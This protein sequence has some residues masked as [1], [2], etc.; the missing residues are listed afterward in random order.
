MRKPGWIPDISDDEITQMLEHITPLVR[1]GGGGGGLRTAEEGDPRT[2]SYAWRPCEDTVVDESELEEIQRI[3]TYHT[4]GHYSMF[5]P[6]VAEV[7]AQ[8]PRELRGT[9]GAFLVI[10]PEDAEALN[11]EKEALDAGYHVAET[12]LYKRKS[13]A[14]PRT[15]WER[16]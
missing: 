13:R 15:A 16:L 12:I 1:S 7:F 6:S 8:I 11:R 4:W 10:G 2:V 3:R 5:K 14:L 9:V